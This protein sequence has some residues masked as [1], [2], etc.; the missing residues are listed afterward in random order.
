M[1]DL[2]TFGETMLRLSPTGG[3]RLSTTDELALRT[4]G[5][6]SNVAIA[7]ARLGTD[8]AWCS[9]L[10]DSP[11]GRRVRRDV[12]THG[13]EPLIAWSDTHRQG[14]Y[15]LDDGEEPRG[16]DVIYDRANAAITTT[17]P[18]DLPLGPLADAELFFTTGITPALSRTLAETTVTLLEGADRTAFDLNYRSKLWSHDEARAAYDSLLPAVDVL[19]APERDALEILGCSGQPREIAADLRDRYGCD[20]VVLTRGEHGALARTP[21]GTV[22]QPV[23]PADT[24][25]PIGTGDA[26]VGGYL[27]QSLAGAGPRRCLAY[28]AATAS[29]KRTVEGDLAVVTPDE[30]AAVLREHRGEAGR[31]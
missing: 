27:S 12:E 26:F 16:T 25:D 11:L 6:E 14:V 21:S 3:E 9:K 30:V 10:P 15:Y 17:T 24:V 31:A 28:A 5:A 19:F 4:A 8:A 18:D 29:L 22:E 2:I 13:V 7:A 23:I 1:A 20:T